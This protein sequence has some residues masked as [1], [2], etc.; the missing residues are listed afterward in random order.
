MM[1]KIDCNH[2]ELTEQILEL[3]PEQRRSEYNSWFNFWLKNNK[4]IPKEN[5]I[6]S[7]NVRALI[8]KINRQWWDTEENKRILEATKLKEFATMTSV[9]SASLYITSK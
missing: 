6:E 2:S 8:V 1:D 4:T 5:G 9:R 3:F 7:T